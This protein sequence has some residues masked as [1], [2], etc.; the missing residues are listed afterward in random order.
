MRTLLSIVTVL[1]TASIAHAQLGG[2]AGTVQDTTRVQTEELELDSASRAGSRLQTTA[3]ASRIDQMRQQRA[4]REARRAAR[5]ARNAVERENATPRL[6]TETQSRSNVTT[7]VEDAASVAATNDGSASADAQRI[8]TETQTQA[9][10]EAVGHA[11]AATRV[12]TRVS[13]EPEAAGAGEAV[14]RIVS[15]TERDAIAARAE[16]SQDAVRAAVQAETLQTGVEVETPQAGV[17]IDTPQ[18]VT[19]GGGSRTVY[20]QPVYDN[21][22]VV[23]RDRGTNTT[24]APATRAPTSQETSRAT[25]ASGRD[26][27]ALPVAARTGLIDMN[28]VSDNAF[29]I[30]CAFLLIA[31]LLMAV[32]LLTRRRHI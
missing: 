9:A 31:A 8:N 10:A 11:D 17:T 12:E 1:V 21:R 15:E 13:A 26:Q 28:S 22:T 6:A 3:P 23:V 29:P 30:S 19:L 7:Q 24:T 25:T 4:L 5:E 14:S 18:A 16:D 27:A 20:T 2:V 32:R